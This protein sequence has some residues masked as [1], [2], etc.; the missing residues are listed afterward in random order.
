MGV[1]FKSVSHVIPN[2]RDNEKINTKIITNKLT[3]LNTITIWE[4]KILI[5][6]GLVF[7]NML[8]PCTFKIQISEILMEF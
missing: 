3:T 1:Y 8:V 7:S 5:Q 2:I 6:H 4:F